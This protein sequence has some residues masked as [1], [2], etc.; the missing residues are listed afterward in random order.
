M[1]RPPKGT[2]ATAGNYYL[3]AGNYY[4]T[5]ERMVP[6]GEQKTDIYR[7]SL[8]CSQEGLKRRYP[9]IEIVDVPYEGASLPAYFLKSP[10]APR[11]A[12]R[13]SC[14]STAST[15]ARR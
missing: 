14:C 12:R 8:R 7:K 15:T 4:Y 10:V 1:R 6:P 11:P 13:P 9:N 5:G 2:H 3:R